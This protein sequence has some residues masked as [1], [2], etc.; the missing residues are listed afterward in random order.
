M[1]TAQKTE[2]ICINGHHYFKSSDCLV[3]PICANNDKPQNGFLSLLAAPARRAL[4]NKGIHNIEQLATFSEQE[5]L[6]FH[7][8]GKNAMIN[9]KLALAS[10][11]LKFRDQ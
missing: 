1:K 5:V 7:G 8:I 3:C 11:Q 2:R 10:N 4:A 9:L 6:S